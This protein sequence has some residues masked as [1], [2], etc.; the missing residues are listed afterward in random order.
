MPI[1][2]IDFLQVEGL[3]P[4]PPPPL[5]PAPSLARC[6]YHYFLFLDMYKY[7]IIRLANRAVFN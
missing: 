6:L 7:W 3:K 2:I 5:P 1:N 4:P